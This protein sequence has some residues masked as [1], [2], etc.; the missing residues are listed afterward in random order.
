[1]SVRWRGH[2]PG[3][4]PEVAM[5][6]FTRLYEENGGVEPEDVV[7]AATPEDAPLHPAFEWDDGVAGAKFRVLTA[8]WM[9][10]SLVA[11]RSEALQVL[12]VVQTEEAGDEP[13]MRCYAL[14]T[15][16]PDDDEGEANRV[17][18]PM[19]VA[20]RDESMRE[21][22]LEQARAELRA[23]TQKWANLDACVELVKGV[24]RLLEEGEQG[25]QGLG[26][27]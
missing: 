9:L 7:E 3:V 16:K 24:R 2:N 6:E 20:V 4:S 10:R 8:A 13:D 22:V 26:A 18:V 1:L 25:P 27:G 12:E 11:P 17:Y 5:A 21:D 19:C 23:F 15:I 14:V